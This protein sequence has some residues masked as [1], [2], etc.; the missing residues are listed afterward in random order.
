MEEP[1]YRQVHKIIALLKLKFDGVAVREKVG[2]DIDKVLS[3]K[4]KALYV[5]PSN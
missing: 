3:S 4:A 1:W 5:T 2:L